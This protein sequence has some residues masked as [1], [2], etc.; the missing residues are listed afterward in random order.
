MEN[1]ITFIKLNKVPH[2]K[3]NESYNY[4]IQ[5]LV[6]KIFDGEINNHAIGYQSSKESN[7]V[8]N[9]FKRNAIGEKNEDLTKE[10]YQQSLNN[11]FFHPEYLGFLERGFVNFILINNRNLLVLKGYRGTGKSELIRYVSKFIS[12]N[13]K[14]DTCQ[15]KD[16][17]PKK[18]QHVIINFNEGEFP[19]N[20]KF[21]SAVS[22]KIFN[23]IAAELGRLISITPI[24]IIDD[25]INICVENYEPFL[26]SVKVEVVD[27]H[28]DWSEF[29]EQQKYN[30][31]YS[32]IRKRFENEYINN[33][34]TAIYKILNHYNSVVCRRAGCFLLIMDNIDQLN[35]E[36]QN[37][38]MVIAKSIN[39]QS[40]IQVIIPVRLT[41]FNNIQG[42]ASI[43]FVACSNIGFSPLNLCL[44]RI[45]HYI[46]NKEEFSD[47][48]GHKFIDGKYRKEFDS[49]LNYIYNGL[50][51]DNQ[52][53]KLRR[54]EKTFEALAGVSIR[55]CLRLFRRLFLNYTIE[56]NDITPHEDM[57]IRSLYSYKYDNG[58]MNIDDDNRIHNIFQ[59]NQTKSLT[60]NNLRI[61]N[62]VY[63]CEQNSISI[64]IR[65][66]FEGL[67]LYN[68]ISEDKFDMYLS[69]LWRQ[70]KR[71]LTLLDVGTNE[72]KDKKYN[73]Q[74]QI[75]K[76]GVKHIDCLCCDLQYLQNCLEIVDLNTKI[77]KGNV[78]EA[79]KYTDDIV[80]NQQIKT[81]LSDS[82]KGIENKRYI[83]FTPNF[84][85]YNDI[86]Q[87][88][89]YI[90][91]MLRLLY[92]KDVVE[93]I[94]YKVRYNTTSE[95]I[96]SISKITNLISI[97]IIIGISNSVMKITQNNQMSFDEREWWKEL[98]HLV[99]EWNL[100][101]FPSSDY[102]TELNKLRN[103]VNQW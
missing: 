89:H 56:W 103:N 75:T 44:L 63:Y 60:L 19:D 51:T 21:S 84:V 67:K 93:T 92:L 33:G 27:K 12:D 10:Q 11:D 102:N 34:L 98:I 100:I 70:G 68:E 52:K 88:I 59:D 40:N 3:G 29:S 26:F 77:V 24:N 81:L 54:L 73:A 39:S 72:E 49:R 18:S 25:F 35:I 96:R 22:I 62:T 47:Y 83:D 38:I 28:I 17:C 15:Y 36:Q 7:I 58:K 90:R 14:H 99:C 5:P 8:A 43:N 79:L 85:D 61:L 101:L 94:H 6:E 97:P 86:N 95:D 78:A 9:N 57:L 23:A 71:V 66:L 74:P 1:E 16:A 48:Y 2:Y 69:V 80:G 4:A 91:I 32:W 30:I 50:T 41:T 65:E 87:R 53:D 55:K 76:S 45:K 42:N 82:L 31:I 13:R 46:E 64:K 20:S 37:K